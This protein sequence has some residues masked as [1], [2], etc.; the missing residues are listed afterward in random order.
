MLLVWIPIVD[1]MSKAFFILRGQSE[2]PKPKSLVKVP[3]FGKKG[4]PLE[5]SAFGGSIK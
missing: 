5:A 4:W 2:R 3:R 1:A